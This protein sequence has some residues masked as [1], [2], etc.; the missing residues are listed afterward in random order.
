MIKLLFL[1]GADKIS[2]DQITHLE[3]SAPNLIIYAIPI[4]GIL[5]LLEI[6]FSHKKEK[7]NYPLKET[8]GSTFVGLGNVALGL[9]VKIGLLYAAIWIY[10]L[11]PWRMELNWWMLIPCY[12]LFDLCSYWSH[13][14]SHENRFFW[15]THIVH[16]RPKTIIFQY[17]LD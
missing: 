13:R 12:L 6:Y 3:K 4:M 17:L 14:I 1:F 7:N 16:H 5:T 15:A 11:V 8:L 2:Y 9:L 10:N